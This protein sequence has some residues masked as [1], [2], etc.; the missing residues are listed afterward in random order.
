MASAR[1]R[2]NPALRIT[3]VAI[4]CGFVAL[5]L[6]WQAAHYQNVMSTLAEWQFNVIGRYYPTFTYLLLVLALTLP[7]LLFFARP[8]VP[9]SRPIDVTMLRS[10][11]TFSRALFATSAALLLVAAGLMLSILRLP[12]DKGPVQELSLDDPVITLP[13]EGLTRIVGTIGYDRTAALDEDLLLSRRSLRFA[14]V[15]PAGS[16]PANIQ[17]FVE[18]PPATDTNRQATA[19]MVGVLRSGGLPG[20]ILRLYRYAGFRVEEPYYVLFTGTRAIRWGRFVIASQL[21]VA[22]FLVLLVAFW[23]RWRSR[24]LLETVNKSAQVE[25]VGA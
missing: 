16:D 18:L 21:I 5:L 12:D 25:T 9:G 17:F 10:A 20:E 8:R 19:T 22:A 15:I 1:R 7:A 24:K 4:W 14:P 11:R 6:L 2:R 13:H 23:Q 3:A